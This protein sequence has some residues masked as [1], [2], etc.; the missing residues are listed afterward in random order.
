MFARDETLC[1]LAVLLP[2]LLTLPALGAEGAAPPLLPAATVTA[3]A[4]EL[5]GESAQRHLE[6]LTRQH[7][8]RGSRGY[9]AAAE[10]LA[11][12]LRAYG[13]SEVR[14]ER[15]PADGKLFYG[16]QRSRPAWDA[17]FAE[18]WEVSD[19]AGRVRLASWEAMP[20]TLAQDSE[21]AEVTTELV[22]VGEGTSASDYTQEVRGKIVLASAQ[23]SEVARLAVE[24]HG[25]VGILSYAQNQR[26]AWW[27][28]DEN[29]VRWGH[30]DTFAPKPSFAF[31]L[32]L[33]QARGLRQRLAKGERIRL[34]AVVR[35]GKHPAPYEVLTAVIPGADPR[36]RQQEIVFSCHLDHPRPGAND[37]AS[38]SATLLEMARTL[39]KLIK[40][41]RM[42]RPART[43]RF[44]WP[45]EIEGTLAF[46]NA[47]PEIA[48]RIKAAVHL[49]MVGGG[50]ET[51]AVFHI[52]RGPAS[53]PSFA[54]DVAEALGAFVNAQTAEFAASG[55]ASWPLVAPEG[56]KEPLRAE[57][58]PLSLG[59][60]H[61]VYSDSSFG[62]PAVY[63]ND[64][65]DRYIHT[66][67][68]T[69]SNIDPTKLKRAGFIAL[70][71]GYFL[72]NARAEDAPALWQILQAHALRR[73]ASLTEQRAGLS[74]DEAGHLT[75]FH[76]AYE[77]ALVASMGEFFDVPRT[78]QAEAEAFLGRLE[79]LVG[80]APAAAAPQ[81]EGSVVFQRSP[82]PKGSLA[83][84]GYDYFSDHY[85][86]ERAKALWL[87]RH[88]GARGSGADY[89]YEALNLVN[90]RRTAQ[91]IRDSLSAIYGP[92]PL[93]VVLEYLRAL[94]SIAVIQAVLPARPLKE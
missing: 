42:A 21:S 75:R 44:V 20:I 5:S 61:Q 35:A 14:I 78:V 59:S 94:E 41:G 34:N 1:R 91:E 50:P 15:L 29:L 53:R 11:E 7:R 30:L 13:L 52:T 57:L 67:L 12:Q 28:E 81:G 86:A 77:R 4:E 25:A 82:R 16:T 27:G 76:L 31:M 2:L 9:R 85:G 37:N 79:Q 18:L 71:T 66:N 3:L 43:L 92:V 24:R 22:D 88:S 64:W 36:L 8:M 32:S 38:G 69:P 68:D 70:A 65:P 90:G 26:T 23:P 6:F 84:F 10:H 60:D 55:R 48:S 45:P 54:Y 47:R 72:A 33:K 56:G 83:A 74:P 39:S 87:L 80:P 73:A 89:A 63:L 40:E 58:V 62:I 51:K 46:L 93:E 17:E 19:T 49:D